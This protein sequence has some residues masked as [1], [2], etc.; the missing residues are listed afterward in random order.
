MA[1]PIPSDFHFYEDLFTRLSTALT[2]YVGGTATGVIAAITPVATTLLSIYV[3]LWGWSMM[4]GV[5]N[6]PVT[7]GV[8]RIVKLSVIVGIA[9]VLGNYNTFLADFLWQT[10]DALASVVV[11]GGSTPI[12][13]VQYLD[14]LMS[15]MYDYGS[16]YYEAAIADTTLG[17]PDLGKLF[18]AYFVWAAG[19]ALTAY[20]AFLYSLAKVSLAIVLGIGP[21]FVLLTMF[22]TTKRFF[23]AWLGQALNAVFSIVLTA[24]VISLVLAIIQAYL[25][26][27]AADSY[28]ATTPIGGAIPAVAFSLIGLLVLMQIPSVASALGG[29]VAV[30]TL[31]A[32]GALAGRARNTAGAGKDLLTGKTLSDYRGARRVKAMNTRWAANNPSAAGQAARNVAGSPAALYRK[33]TGGN[34]NRATRG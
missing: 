4:R 20:G 16:A 31:G 8:T 6:E 2:T 34:R 25:G 17:I 29:G 7:D 32:V 11:G 18:T 21:I 9:L 22:E 10:P 13:G 3:V 27:P 12:N 28:K 33:V 14:G 30:G 23:D 5:I 26:S 1:A 24:A 19:V 15:N